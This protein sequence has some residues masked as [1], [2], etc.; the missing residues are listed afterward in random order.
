[1]FS[2]ILRSSGMYGRFCRPPITSS[3]HPLVRWKASANRL[4]LA[5]LIAAGYAQPWHPVWQWDERGEEIK[6]SV[7]MA[8]RALHLDFTKNTWSRKIVDSRRPERRVIEFLKT[9][10]REIVP[11]KT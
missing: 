2:H 7:N 1:V 10:A 3:L 5:G 9:G 4:E 8:H 11:P 6:L